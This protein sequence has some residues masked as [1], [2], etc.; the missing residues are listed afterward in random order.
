MGLATMCA[1]MFTAKEELSCRKLLPG[2]LSYA[3]AP[4]AGRCASSPGLA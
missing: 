1:P 2:S 3:A 4:P